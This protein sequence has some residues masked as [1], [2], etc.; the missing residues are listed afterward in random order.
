L[1]YFIELPEGKAMVFLLHSEETLLMHYEFDEVEVE[2]IERVFYIF[3]IIKIRT[4]VEK[5]N[6]Q[7]KKAEVEL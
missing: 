3:I 6:Y 1:K 5:L 7:E 2:V 4:L